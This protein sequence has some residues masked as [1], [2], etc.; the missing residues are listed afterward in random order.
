MLASMPGSAC[1]CGCRGG[2]RVLGVDDFGDILET[3]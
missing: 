1:D 3:P 2:V